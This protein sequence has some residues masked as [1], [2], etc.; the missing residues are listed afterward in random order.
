MNYIKG[1]D[2]I[3]AVALI[4][5]FYSHLSTFNFIHD[6]TERTRIEMICSGDSGVRLFF[7]LSGFLITL[8]LMR[9]KLSSGKID[10]KYFYLRRALKIIP[11]PLIYYFILTLLMSLGYIEHQW[12]GLAISFFYLYNFVP[13]IY[14]TSELGPTWSLGVEEQFYL[15][16]PL[17]ISFFSNRI[18]RIAIFI[19]GVCW[20][21]YLYLP[22]IVINFNS[23]PHLLNKY[24]FVRR[25]FLPACAPIITGALF[26]YLYVTNEEKCQRFFVK[27][28]SMFISACILFFLPLYCPVW[29]LP[30]TYPLQIIQAVGTSIMLIWIVFN[31]NSF[32]TRL[33]DFKPLAYIGKISYGLYIYH[34]IFI[35]TGPGSLY[36]Q[37]YPLNIFL[38]FAIAVLSYEF[39]EK[40]ILKNKELIYVTLKNMKYRKSN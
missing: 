13:S 27:K 37:Q 31:Q 34:G 25:W 38:T 11:P 24:F 28:S 4:M 17:I 18:V 33:L 36:I 8:L 9:E 29:F 6:F 26:S 19:L 12:T 14:Y 30:Y 10:V 20:L 7:S 22:V 39:Y 15:L 40:P 35:G 5:V 1:Y 3:R 23:Q 2:G 16:W 21:A 32:F